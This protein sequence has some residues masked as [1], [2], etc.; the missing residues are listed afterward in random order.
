MS[1]IETHP[2]QAFVP[3]GAVVLIVGSFPGKGQ[4]NL[5]SIN[6]SW[7]YGS[8]RNQ[9]WSILSAVYAVEL[10]AIEIKKQLFTE[11]KI[12]IVDIFLK[13]KRRENNNLDTNLEVIE[14]N[15]KA[16]QKILQENNFRSILFTSKFVEKEFRKLF[17]QISNGRCLPS[18]SPRYARM[19]KMG[20]VDVYKSILPK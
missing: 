5:E 9:F 7:F 4:T 2:F 8:K 12:A 1:D 14:Y 16:I 3:K 11:K 13:V 20:K 6:D 15:D 10:N 19:K 18:P 17:P